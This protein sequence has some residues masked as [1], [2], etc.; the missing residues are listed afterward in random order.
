ML[1]QSL[2]SIPFLAPWIPR[3]QKNPEN[4][5]RT[6]SQLCRSVSYS[7]R[8]RTQCTPKSSIVFWVL[9]ARSHIPNTDRAPI[10][11]YEGPFL[12]LNVGGKV[13]L[14]LVVVKKQQLRVFFWEV[15]KGIG[16][17]NI[18]QFLLVK[19]FPLSFHPGFPNLLTNGPQF[20]P[21][22]INSSTKSFPL[23]NPSKIPIGW[24]FV[25]VKHVKN[26]GLLW[27]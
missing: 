12:I 1:Q 24:N 18:S 25:H 2:A 17:K 10:F 4:S 27:L 21:G 14:S 9:A 11:T 26:R 19:T 5:G 20:L 13:V 22:E 3:Y 15:W 6:T 23:V 16:C 7:A 8:K